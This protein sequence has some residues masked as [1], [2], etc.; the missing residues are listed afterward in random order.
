MNLVPSKERSINGP[1]SGSLPGRILIAAAGLA[2]NTAWGA[3]DTN[4]FPGST[5]SPS[6]PDGGPSLLRVIGALA[7]VLGLFLGGAWLVRNG[8][9]SAFGKGR[10]A[11]LNV[12]ESKSLGGRQ[13]IYVV[14]YGQERF[15]IGSTPAGINLLSHL[16]ASEETGNE[17]P[18]A[19]PATNLSFAQALAQVIRGQKPDSGKGGGSA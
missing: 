19:P 3:T 11:R 8:R 1:S 5:F 17:A 18:S 9:F 4:L 7:L 13:A 12:L 15:M 10:A 2:F 14:A 6:L 16:A